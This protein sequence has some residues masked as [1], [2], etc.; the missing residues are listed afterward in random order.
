MTSVCSLSNMLHTQF[1]ERT[2]DTRRGQWVESFD[3][4]KKVSLPKQKK[5]KQ[6]TKALLQCVI[7]LQFYGGVLLTFHKQRVSAN[8]LPTGAPSGHLCLSTQ[9]TRCLRC[10][11]ST[12]EINVFTAPPEWVEVKGP[13]QLHIPNSCSLI[14]IHAAVTFLNSLIKSRSKWD[15]IHTF[16]LTWK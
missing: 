4:V 5:K 6:S 16:C 9:R 12:V 1:I 7:V 14:H 10:H 11:K 8:L 15:L 13:L 2:E 3:T